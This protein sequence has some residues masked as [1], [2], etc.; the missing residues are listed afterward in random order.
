MTDSSSKGETERYLDA[1]WDEICEFKDRWTPGWRYDDPLNYALGY[2]GE[3]AELV[4]IYKHRRGM[5]SQ[6]KTFTK[7]EVGEELGDGFFYWLMTCVTEGFT[8][9]EIVSI[10]RRKA[11]VIE[12]R[13]RDRANGGNGQIAME[14]P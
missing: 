11:K 5:G 8:K 7:D 12:E 13:F 1:V 14:H 6:L 9:E 3:T 10:M 4:D 2:F